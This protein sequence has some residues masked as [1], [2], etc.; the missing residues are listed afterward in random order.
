[1]GIIRIWFCKGRCS[2]K[3]QK[4]FA[5]YELKYLITREQKEI[6]LNGLKWY[7]HPRWIRK[8]H[9]LQSL[10]RYTGLSADKTFDRTPFVQRKAACTKLRLAVSD[11]KGNIVLNFTPEKTYACAVIS[12]PDIKKRDLCCLVGQWKCDGQD[13]RYGR[14]VAKRLRRFG[15]NRPCGEF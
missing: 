6:I 9:G 2:V 13:D 1:M 3:I 12:S 7:M 5:R 8:K 4:V 10:L 14:R 11:S 15:G